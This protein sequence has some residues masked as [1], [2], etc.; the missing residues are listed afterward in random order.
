MFEHFS[1]KT[2]A[3]PIIRPHHHLHHMALDLPA[4]SSHLQKTVPS[5]VEGPLEL[6]HVAVLLWIDEL[7]GEVTTRKGVM[8]EI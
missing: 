1:K 2:I 3:W 6:Q 4:T 5:R 7:I 8:H